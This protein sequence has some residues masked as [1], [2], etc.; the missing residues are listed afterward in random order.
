MEDLLLRP[1][2]DAFLQVGVPVAVLVL[3]VAWAQVRYGT[4]ALDVL[5]RHRRAAPLLGAVLGVTPGCGG[6]ILAVGL[7]LKR[8]ASYG[9]AVA[10]LTATMGDASFVLLAVDLR[11]GLLVHGALLL[12]GVVTGY[13]VDAVGWDPRRAPEQ[14]PVAVAAAGGSGGSAFAVPVDTGVATGAGGCSTAPPAGVWLPALAL[15]TATAV[16]ALLAVPAA[17]SLL[18][19]ADAVVAGLDLWL[20]A[21]V[22]GFV[23]CLAVFLRAGCRL[24]DDGEDVPLRLSAALAHGAVETAFVVFWVGA[25][26]V[27]MAVLG[28]LVPWT[29]TPLPLVGALGVAV[30]VV[31]A[32]VP[33]C[34]TQIAFTGLY[35]TGALPL[36]ALLANAVAQDGD[37]LLPLLARDRRTAVLTTV[38]TSAPALVAGGVALALA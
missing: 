25:A 6:A 20:V 33:G 24:R 13:A 19:P 12:T 29:G 5:V 32:L 38:L 34:G 21:G 10:A 28:E 18:D 7:Y 9:T 31:V 22:A 35:A 23:A 27:V 1:L 3:A 37:A 36:P 17:L 11:V 15:W 8:R 2:A 16:G 4:R 26:F 14:V 30:G